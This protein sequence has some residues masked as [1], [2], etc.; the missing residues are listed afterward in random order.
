MRK[1]LI[2]GAGGAGSVEIWKL[3]NRRYKLYFCDQEISLI[4]NLIP[5]NKKF[6][7]VNANSKNYIKSITAIIKKLKIDL[8]VPGVDEEISSL[9]SKKNNIKNIFCPSKKM[10]LIFLD[11]FKT[12]TLLKKNKFCDLNTQIVKSKKNFP[13]NKNLIV[14]PRLGRGSRMVHRISN[15]FQFKSYLNLYKLKTSEVI[16]QKFIEGQEYTVFVHSDEDGKLRSVVPVKVLS[17]K[18]VTLHGVTENNKMIINFIKEFNN[19]FKIQNCYNVQLI[20][21]KKNIY[22][23]EINPRISTTFIMTLKLGYDPFSKLGGE[24]IFVPKKK[25]ILKRFWNNVFYEKKYN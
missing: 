14:K 23:I 19:K 4:N 17:K 11:K 20:I 15:F 16:I 5:S 1:I 21:K 7:V 3:L 24:T 13:I 8:L 12:S 2:T 25:L 10:S 9:F 6:Q 22:V 18:G